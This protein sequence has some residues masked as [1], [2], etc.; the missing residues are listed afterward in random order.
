MTLKEAIRIL[1]LSGV[2]MYCKVCTVDAV[3]EQ[4]RTVDCT[5]IDEGAPLVG[6]NLQASQEGSVGI[7]VFPTVGSYV[8]V[9]FLDPAVA[10]VL[11]TEEVGKV[12]INI[13]RTSATVTDE[14]LDAAIGDTTVRITADGITLNGGRLGGLVKIEELTRT[15]NNLIRA[16]NNHTH[17]LPTGAVAV[18][19]SAT[20]QANPA[21]V[22]IPA[23]TQGHPMVA[24]QDYEDAKVKH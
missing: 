4:A 3:D 19:G 17:E 13:G 21:P 7:V 6:V 5:P 20:A 12:R 18:T 9:G 16:F 15:L 2:E 22:V 1:A 14:G 11:L 24:T 23:P 10:A 8:L